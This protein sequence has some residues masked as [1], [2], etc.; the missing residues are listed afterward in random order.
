MGHLHT[1]ADGHLP[2]FIKTLATLKGSRA[3]VR[4]RLPNNFHSLP[5]VAT[6]SSSEV[7][8]KTPERVEPSSI[9][10][11]TSEIP[12]CYSSKLGYDSDVL[13]KADFFGIV[14]CQET[15]APIHG[16]KAMATLQLWI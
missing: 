8:R 13:E 5:A 7:V 15:M 11:E 16:W 1:Q 4:I 2:R 6:I 14:G 10:S 9:D 12:G 3:K